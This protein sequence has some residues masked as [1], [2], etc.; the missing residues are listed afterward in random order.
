MRDLLSLTFGVLQLQKSAPASVG[1]TCIARENWWKLRLV[2]RP[3]TFIP[4]WRPGC[5]IQGI[6]GTEGKRSQITSAPPGHRGVGSQASRIILFWNLHLSQMICR[7]HF[8]CPTCQVACCFRICHRYLQCGMLS[9]ARLWKSNQNNIRKWITKNTVTRVIINI[10]SLLARILIRQI[11][12]E[13][14]LLTVATYIKSS[15]ICRTSHSYNVNVNIAVSFNSDAYDLARLLDIITLG[16]G[17]S[18]ITASNGHSR[19]TTIFALRMK[20]KSELFLEI[21]DIH[22]L[23]GRKKAWGSRYAAKSSCPFKLLPSWSQ[24][25][26]LISRSQSCF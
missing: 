3:P 7:F 5:T 9:Y 25:Q 22:L 8:N 10:L 11:E 6:Y 18:R 23:L 14:I 26:G 1:G 24:N 17:D 12:R 2:R 13:V 20:L 19:T 4:G 21:M 16:T 15:H